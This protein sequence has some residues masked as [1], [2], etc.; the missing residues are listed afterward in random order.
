MISC[1]ISS[2]SNSFLNQVTESIKAT[3]DVPFEVIAINNRK[4]EK[5]ICEVYNNGAEK[6]KY[7]FLCFLHEDVLFETQ[8]WGKNA[9]KHF[10]DNTQLGMIG[11]AGCKI[12]SDI[13]SS[14]FIPETNSP[15]PNRYNYKA[16]SKK[17]PDIT[18]SMYMNPDEEILSEVVCLDG[19]FLLTQKNIWEKYKFDETLLRHFH[20]YDLDFSLHI[21]QHFKIAVA[22]DILLT[23][24]S[25]G[26]ANDAWVKETFK[27]YIKW[28]NKLPLFSGHGV[29]LI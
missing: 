21:Q 19:V 22:Y 13:I 23:H 3:I 5:G 7:P 20:G 10:E 29:D 17:S 25:D 1:I 2:V 14:W 6:A 12:K 9:L 24:V 8:G 27:V 16:S 26:Y 4:G 28:K 15:S 18:T 11:V